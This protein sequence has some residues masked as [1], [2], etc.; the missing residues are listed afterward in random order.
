MDQSLRPVLPNL[1]LLLGYVL[2]LATNK[3]SL[4]SSVNLQKYSL[5]DAELSGSREWHP[6]ARDWYGLYAQ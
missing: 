1:S 2:L 4:P 5:V 6:P 3:L